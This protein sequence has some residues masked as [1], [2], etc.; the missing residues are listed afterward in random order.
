MA[1]LLKESLI[2][3]AHKIPKLLANNYTSMDWNS[4]ETTDKP[5]IL[6]FFEQLNWS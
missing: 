1:N 6:D 2:S 3:F 5:N 4:A